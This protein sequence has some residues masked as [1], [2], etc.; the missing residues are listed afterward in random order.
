MTPEGAA[1]VF[2]V[3]YWTTVL[4]SSYIDDVKHMIATLICHVR[5]VHVRV[6]SNTI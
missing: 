3:L 4:E 2:A 5:T 6:V 1:V